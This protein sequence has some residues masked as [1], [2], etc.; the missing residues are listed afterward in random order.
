MGT[1]MDP[2]ELHYNNQQA[3]K[4]GFG[5]HIVDFIQTLVVFAA[6][7]T[8]VYM[9]V[10]RPHKVSGNSMFPNFHN[11]DFIITEQISYHFS[12]PQRGDIVVFK[13]PREESKDFIK[14]II[15]KP[16]ERVKL[17]NGHF[18][19]N[20]QLLNEPYLATD[21]TTPPGSFLQEGSEIVVPPKTFFATGDNRHNSTD[22]REIGPISDKELKGRVILRYWPVDTF[23]VMPAAYTFKEKF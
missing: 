16:G 4:S 8:A 13:N 19:I 12:E 14:R 3:P 1:L 9:W 15:G 20:G 2:N 11:G 17:E 10:A 6:I 18:Y 7:G 21:L 22:S 5:S 23:G